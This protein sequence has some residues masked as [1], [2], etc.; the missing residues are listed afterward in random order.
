MEGKHLSK[1]RPSRQWFHRF[2]DRYPEISKRK[3]QDVRVAT[4]FVTEAK[5]RGW[6]ADMEKVLLADLG[7][8]QRMA[9]Y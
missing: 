2:L 4:G 8:L 9:N 5:I 7:V 6:F 3:T 1:I